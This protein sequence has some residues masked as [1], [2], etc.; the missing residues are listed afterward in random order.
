MNNEGPQENSADCVSL[1][2]TRL[3][4]L[5]SEKGG[6]WASNAKLPWKDMPSQLAKRG[7]VLHNWPE[8][9]DLPGKGSRGIWVL[10]FDRLKV[11]LNAL[12]DKTNPMYFENIGPTGINGMFAMYLFIFYLADSFRQSF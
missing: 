7:F 8:E 6:S 1:I 3:T 4:A 2:K 11:L 5:L 10:K 12:H 9:V